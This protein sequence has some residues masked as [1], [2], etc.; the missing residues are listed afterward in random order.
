MRAGCGE[1]EDAEAEDSRSSHRNTMGFRRAPAEAPVD[2]SAE[3]SHA[4]VLRLS[5]EAPVSPGAALR[6]GAGVSRQT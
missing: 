5:D 2:C 6:Q 4:S 3:D 1:E